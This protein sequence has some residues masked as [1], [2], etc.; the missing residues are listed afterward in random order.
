[1]TTTQDLI[2]QLRAL[3]IPDWA[4]ARV[5]MTQ[6]ADTLEALQAEHTDEVMRG[7]MLEKAHAM[8]LAE[9][10]AAL[11]RLAELEKQE[12]VIYQAKT[13]P[14]FLSTS[15]YAWEDCEKAD[16][17]VYEAD[18]VHVRGLYAAAGASLV[19]TPIVAWAKSTPR[20]LRITTMDMGGEDGW[21]PLGYTAAGAFPVEPSQ[22]QPEPVNVGLMELLEPAFTEIQHVLGSTLEVPYQ[23]KSLETALELVRAAIAVIKQ[24][25][26]DYEAMHKKGFQAF[27]CPVCGFDGA[28][29]FQPAAQPSQALELVNTQRVCFIRGWDAR[30]MF[31]G[32]ESSE[33]RDMRMRELLDAY[34]PRAAINAKEQPNG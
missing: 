3:G 10:D 25:Q 9:R 13:K 21:R 20:K 7:L 33:E 30:G 29:G 19:A 26:P 27:D 1:M 28:L 15:A 18:G 22:A 8:G 31:S 23:R 6:A 5:L 34:Y 17:L 32:P 12:P 24:S 11:A 14:G 4:M 16:F 2:A